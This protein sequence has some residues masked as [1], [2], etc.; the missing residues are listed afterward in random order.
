M[1]TI[2]NSGKFESVPKNIRLIS[3]PGDELNC[4]FYS[5][6]IDARIASTRHHSL[7]NLVRRKS[8][9]WLR[10]HHPEKTRLIGEVE[11]GGYVDTEMLCYLAEMCNFRVKVLTV[12]RVSS[13]EE[14]VIEGWD[15]TEE[16]NTHLPADNTL[17]AFIDEEE[18][19]L[20]YGIPR[21]ELRQE[22]L[23][24]K[25]KKPDLAQVSEEKVG[26]LL[27]DTRAAVARGNALLTLEDAE[28]EPVQSGDWYYRAVEQQ[29]KSVNEIKL[30]L[31]EGHYNRQQN[32]K[33]MWS[34]DLLGEEEP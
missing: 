15:G 13:K 5:V 32:N 29:G 21:R 3:V 27:A 9:T 11:D 26:E 17:F 7:A 14:Y 1:K 12:K 10:I 19:H 34:Y 16:F 33:R 8:A 4:V 25:L 23:V 31:A 30:R 18:E 22:T 20:T 28:A 2:T 24:V 6:L